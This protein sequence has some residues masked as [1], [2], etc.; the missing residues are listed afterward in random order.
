MGTIT[1]F[2]KEKLIIGVLSTDEDK[3]SSV[4]E[5]LEEDYGPIDFSSPPLSFNFTDYYHKEMGENILRRFFSF[6]E[7]KNPGGL[8]EIKVLTNQLEEEVKD[9][10]KRRVNLDPGFLNRN[11]LIL[12]S[13]KDAPHRIPLSQGIYAEITLRYMK[14]KFQELPWTY[15]D[16]RSHVYQTILEKIRIC[17]LEQ[18]RK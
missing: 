6:Q 13:T 15:P 14:G 11:R 1:P 12:A 3:L 17:Y 8:A 9:E 4:R 16:F 5:K 10:G 18:L 7:L 2:K